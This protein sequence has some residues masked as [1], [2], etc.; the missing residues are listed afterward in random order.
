MLCL[1][2][3]YTCE[4]ETGACRMKTDTLNVPSQMVVPLVY[5]VFLSSALNYSLISFCNK[6]CDTSVVSAFWPLQVGVAVILSYFVFGDT[7]NAEQGPAPKPK[8]RAAYSAVGGQGD[9]CVCGWSGGLEADRGRR[10]R[11]SFLKLLW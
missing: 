8:T 7:I 11:L 5:A 1:A 10:R 6:N 3:R 4:V 2:P 9:V